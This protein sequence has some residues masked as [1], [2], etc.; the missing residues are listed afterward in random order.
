RYARACKEAVRKTAVAQAA[1]AR[2]EADLRAV[3]GLFYFGHGTERLELAGRTLAFVERSRRLPK[4]AAELAAAEQA[5]EQFTHRPGPNGRELYLGICRLR[6]KIILSHPLLDFDRLL[7]NKRPPP[8]YSHMCDQYLGRHSRLGPGLVVLDDWKDKPRETLLLEGKLPPGS[9]LHPDLSYDA[10]RV[11]FSYCDHSVKD[12]RCRR[13]FIHEI[14]ID[15]SRLR[16]L[17]GTASDPLAGWDGRHTVLIEDFD[18]CYL[19]DGSIVFITTRSQNFGRCHGGR[20]TPAYLLY[21]MGPDGSG[22]HQISFGEANEWDPSV[23]HDGRI[24]Y[25]RWDYINRHD[26]IFQ[27]LWT[28]HPDGTATAHYYG[29]YSRAPCMIAESRSVPGSHKVVATTTAHHGYTTGSTI[30]IDP[31]IGRDDLEPLTR[32]TPEISFP[33]APDRGTFVDGAFATPWPLSEDLFLAAYTPD[34]RVGQGSVQAV[35]AYSIY[36]VDMLGGRELIYRDPNMSCF[37]PIPIQPRPR[38]PVLSSTTAGGRGAKTG[39]FFVQDVY[40]STQP[41][42]RGSI[43]SI[44]VNRIY[45]QPTASH[46]HRSRVNNEVTKGILGT[47]P[48]GAD[49][50]TAFRAPAGV[51]M[52]LQVLDANGMAVMTMRSVVYLQPGEVSGCVGCHEPRHATSRP[53]AGRAGPRIHDITPPAG[54]K[55][56]GGFSFVRTVQ[57]VLDRYCIRCHGLNAG[58]VAG[59]LNLLGT[60]A[61]G[62]NAAYCSL[63]DRKGLVR[64]AQRNGETWYSKPKDYFAHAGKL[65][66]HLTGRH[67]EKVRLDRE[68]FRR[69]VDWL[70]VNAQFYGDYSR[71]RL[72]D[73][74]I[75]KEGEKALREHVRGVF[76]EELA[77]QPFAALVNAAMPMESRIL[78]APLAAEAGGWG[79]ITKGGWRDTRE[80]GYR[81][82]LKLVTAAVEPLEYHDIAGGCGH[83]HCRCG[84][85]WVRKAEEDYRESLAAKARIAGR[86]ESR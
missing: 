83:R 80:A 42:E 6:R 65:V 75:S 86:D 28:M 41:I 49:G 58:K 71:N 43:K 20:Y 68:S 84:S 10:R 60:P 34:R 67:R 13:F 7:I 45:C 23:M 69:I 55:Y 36:L 11:L 76:G 35:N 32:V 30:L 2:T 46:P 54:P 26:T 52:Q 3:R 12:Q 22:I 66:G 53:P 40:R 24:V 17:T 63:M 77:A 29:N 44:R 79:Q 1:S 81:E 85:C 70:D 33:E 39:L 82:M 72:E 8:N 50:S 37:T 25:T 73:R 57:P 56:E 47:V 19:P 21:R 78:K 48:V 9:V 64:I 14:G 38:P 51:P 61:D 4:L 31:L 15:G 18:P 59:D 74:G 62:F 16:Q 5:F 27:S